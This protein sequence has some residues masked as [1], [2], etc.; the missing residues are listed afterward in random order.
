M[1]KVLIIILL[2][3]SFNVVSKELPTSLFGIELGTSIEKYLLD[4]NTLSEKNTKGKNENDVGFRSECNTNE[5]IDNLAGKIWEKEEDI[6]INLIQN[7]NFH[8]QCVTWDEQNLVTS[9]SASINYR[10]EDNFK[11]SP[12]NLLGVNFPNQ[13]DL[14]EFIEFKYELESSIAKLYNFD[15]DRYRKYYK[16]NEVNDE[17]T[18]ESIEAHSY[19]DY[20]IFKN[21]EKSHNAIISSIYLKTNKEGGGRIYLEIS[22]S[23]VKDGDKNIESE[24]KKLKYFTDTNIFLEKIE[25]IYDDKLFGF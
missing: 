2:F 5:H 23:K 16:F 8:Y 4:K 17:Y 24:L 14:K 25:Q 6:D 21:D 18:K 22:L 20:I 3:T 10:F 15:V 7:N 19:M 11:Q 9:V 1:N 13:I 12:S